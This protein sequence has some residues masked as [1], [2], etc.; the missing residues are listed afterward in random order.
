[1]A[2]PSNGDYSFSVAGHLSPELRIG[3]A[4]R[5]RAASDLSEHLAAGRLTTEEFDERVQRVYGARTAS[6]LEPLFRDLP[7][8]HPAPPPRRRIDLRP[9]MI[10]LLIAAV[11]ASM[12]FLRFVPFFLFPLVWIFFFGGFGRFRGPRGGGRRYAPRW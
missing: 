3:Y 12:A 4:E 1:M 5:E 7:D 6:D 10:A 11:L 9:L 8:L 2:R